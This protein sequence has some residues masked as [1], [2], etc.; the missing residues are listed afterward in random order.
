LRGKRLCDLARRDTQV[1]RHWC[2]IA[3]QAAHN[4]FDQ[5]RDRRHK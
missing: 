5:A 3:T 1:R 4:E 2:V